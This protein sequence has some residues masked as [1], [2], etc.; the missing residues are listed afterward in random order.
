MSFSNSKPVQPIRPA[1][2]LDWG[3]T[4]FLTL[5]PL[6]ALI[7]LPLY[8]YY[9]DI[10]L[11]VFGVFVFYMAATGL[12]ITAGYHRFFSHRSFTA[13][14]I[15]KLFFLIFGAAACQNSA[16]K[17][18]SDHRKHHRYVDQEG[19]PY[20]I[21]LGFF[22]AHIGWVLRKARKDSSLENARDLSDDPMIMWQHKYYLPLAI[23]VG[24]GVPLLIGVLFNAPLGCFLLAGIVRTVIVHHCTFLINSLCHFMGK[25]PYSL[26]DT[27]RDSPWVALLTYGE[28]Y[29]NFHHRFKFDYRNGIRWFHIDP[30]KWLIKTLELFGLAGDLRK[31][32]DAHIF[33][34]RWEVQKERVQENLSGFS[35]E[36]RELMERK[37]H[38]TYEKLLLAYERLGNIR[39]EYLLFRESLDS[40][41]GEMILKL[42]TDLQYAKS[43]FKEIHSSWA[44]LV[45]ECCPTPA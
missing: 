24:G 37:V 4:L 25:Q 16:L 40:K 2:P 43:Q 23:G 27:S 6:I 21:R 10:P 1:L 7:G 26:K 38:T 41:G 35:E 9:W 3:N 30:S 18:A 42:K 8:L 33:K 19:D 36:F 45:Q 39:K 12:S 14:P 17:W 28:G 15:V 20:N 31:A 13:K 11:P 32:S 29:H 34:A 5:T 44:L 22:Y